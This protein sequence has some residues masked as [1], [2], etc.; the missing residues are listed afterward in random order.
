MSLNLDSLPETLG[1]DELFEVFKQFYESLDV[2]KNLD[3]LQMIIDAMSMYFDEESILSL[4]P[5]YT[6]LMQLKTDTEKMMIQS[7][8]QANYYDII[9]YKAPITRR[10]VR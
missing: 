2:I 7:A 8:P 6:E 5:Y 10:E 9:D 1:N 3:D 4:I